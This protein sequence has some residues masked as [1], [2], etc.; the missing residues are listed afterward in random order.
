MC[1]KHAPSC[2]PVN[3]SETTIGNLLSD[4]GMRFLV[5]ELINETDLSSSFIDCESLTLMCAPNFTYVVAH[6]ETRVP[7]SSFK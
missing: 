5:N 6:P 3:P 7:T 2:S 4:R 1:S